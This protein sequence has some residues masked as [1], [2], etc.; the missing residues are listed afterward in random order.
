MFAVYLYETRVGTLAPRGRGIRFTYVPEALDNNALPALSLS[1]PK[2]P[3]PFPDTQAGP[4]FRNLLPE[5]AFL[6]LVAA[7]AGTSPENTLDLVGAI[8]GECPGAVSIW[9]EGSGPPASPQYEPMDREALQALFSPGNRQPLASAITRGR[10]SLAGVQ[11]KIA[12]LRDDS[13]RWH[14]P[15][16]GAVTSHILKEPL[17]T[18]PALLENELFCMTLA[19]RCGIDVPPVG[20]AD[21]EVRMYCVER[22][23]RPRTPAASPMPR[24]RLHQ[25]DFC[26]ILRVEPAR[27]YQA[28]GGP[29]LRRCADVIRQ[30]SRLPAEDLLRFLR[31]VG[32]NF[33][34]GNEDTHAKNLALL[35]TPE[36]L[37]LTP[38]YDLV[39]TQVYP[40]LQR[41]LAMKIGSA[42][43]SRN[44]QANDWQRLAAWMDLPWDLVRQSLLEL[45][46]TVE[47]QVDGTREAC[48]Y[49]YGASDM[50]DRI[51]QVVH[52]RAEQLHRYLTQGP[53]GGAEAFA[54]ELERALRGAGYETLRDVPVRTG[55]RI[56]MLASKDGVKLGVEVKLTNRGLLD[57]L[58]KS[59]QIL[60]LPDVDQMYVAG[61]RGLM[62]QDVKALA[63]QLGVGLLSLGDGGEIEWLLQGKVL[64]PARLTLGGSYASAA[65][66][67]GEAVYRVT[68][69]NMGQKA[70]VGVEVRMVVAGP[71]VAPHPSK[72]RAK[73]LLIPPQD[74]WSTTLS[75]NVKQDAKPGKYPLL[76]TV[77]AENTERQDSTLYYQIGASDKGEP[78]G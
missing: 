45:V 66:P 12:L 10:L 74:Q 33:L 42:W 65:R 36:G 18:Y 24:A 29:G 50:Y 1:L 41:S 21:P 47:R 32:F 68:V 73:R 38:H 25:E 15:R 30:H 71:F 17:P 4:F 78:A 67:G 37:R 57:D 69:F 39:S 19:R 27:K 31:W 49:P 8:G 16:G 5:Q 56:D 75:C 20:L 70:A 11:Q 44:V 7:A 26:Q 61:P 23:D 54:F 59:Q 9:P 13:G 52:T 46:D 3:E 58:T 43:D 34:I 6:R 53:H 76:L 72:T 2:R 77:K 51:G 55:R 35:Y 14:L 48:A 64:E 63:N 62:S 60:R 28:E 22:F 40:D